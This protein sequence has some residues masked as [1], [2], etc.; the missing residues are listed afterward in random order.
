MLRKQW[1]SLETAG[2]RC[3]FD[4]PIFIGTLNNVFTLPLGFQ[5]TAD[6]SYQSRGDA[7]NGIC[8][9]PLY[10]LNVGLRK[11]FLHDALSIEARGN[12]LL[13]GGKQE[14]RLYMQS[15]QL[16][17]LTWSDSRSFSFTVRY[18]FNAVKSKYKGTG[19]GQDAKARF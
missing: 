4:N 14:F 16:N 12:D 5:L 15:A 17:D 9:R 2:Q 8:E 3:T 19:A 11:S 13:L 7:Q 10:F 6:F 1:L 18:K